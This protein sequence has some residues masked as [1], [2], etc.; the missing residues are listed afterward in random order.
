MTT[1]EVPA[2][3]LVPVTLEAERRVTL[4]GADSSPRRLERMSLGRP[5]CVALNAAAVDEE[6]RAFLR[7]NPGST[8]HLLALTASFVADTE[9]PLV[10]AWVDVTLCTNEPADAAEPVA[11]SMTPLSEADSLSI[12]RKI[13][14]NGS[15]KFTI[16]SMEIGPDL[17]SEQVTSYTRPEVSIEALHEGTNRPRWAFYAT[18]VSQ[19]RGIHRLFLIVEKPAIAT[20]AATVSVGA[21]AQLRRLKIF[22]YTAALTHLPE[23]AR[24]TIPSA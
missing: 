15:L 4:G 7:A 13:S 9:N 19:I 3:V 12:S 2:A 14:F 8:F 6:A 16:A 10:S 5:V 11:W 20:A 23:L 21:T 1:I 18:S 17:G 22:R 24:I